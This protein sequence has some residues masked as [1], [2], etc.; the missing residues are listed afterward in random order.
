MTSGPTPVNS[1]HTESLLIPKSLRAKRN[2]RPHGDDGRDAS[3]AQ[4]GRSPA[5]KDRDRL[6]YADAFHRLN[7]VTQV[8]SPS[9]RAP[10]LHNRLTHSMK[11][12]QVARSVAEQLIRRSHDDEG[13]KAHILRHGGVDADVAEA[14]ALA[15]DLG[16]PPFGHIAEQ[17]LD[18]IARND[19]SRIAHDGFEGNAQTFRI[20]TKTEP[21]KTPGY[22]L[23]L[24]RA[25][26]AA[27][28]KYP[29]GRPVE[30]IDDPYMHHE[31]MRTDVSYRL[32]W[33][34]FGY[35]SSERND[36]SDARKWMPKHMRDREKPSQ[37]L[38]ATIMDIADD[39]AYAIHD[40]EDFYKANILDISAIRAELKDYLKGERRYSGKVFAKLADRLSVTYPELY[41][42]SSLRKVIKKI[43]IPTVDTYFRAEYHGEDVELR[44][45]RRFASAAVSDLVNAVQPRDSP[46]T[47]VGAY[48][49]LSTDAWHVVQVYK[50]IMKE[51]VIERSDIALV[52]RSQTALIRELHG[53][54]VQW[55]E[56]CRSRGRITLLPARL[57]GEFGIYGIDTR[58]GDSERI[59]IDYLC[60]LTDAQVYQMYSS[61]R[62]L[63]MPDIVTMGF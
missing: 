62:S 29:W 37:S 17:E 21:Y 54:L 16:H 2:R 41:S 27:V 42:Q 57:R 12:A 35:Y 61:L 9:L 20:I 58:F 51:F 18:R 30:H 25:T 26:R 50:A 14:A 44:T 43:I 15:H 34:K 13:L 52:Q 6:F 31:R 53:E 59:Y 40:I 56:E 11:V 3:V 60:T 8:L 36:F 1:V 24:T 48:L 28:L 49:E 47:E 23:S 39:I 19:K 10:A 63:H 22:G 46:G 33:T 4:S 45:I 5:R 32:R 7:G 55:R 38:E